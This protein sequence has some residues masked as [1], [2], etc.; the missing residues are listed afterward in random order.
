MDPAGSCFIMLGTVIQLNCGTHKFPV[1]KTNK[2]SQQENKLKSSGQVSDTK[3]TFRIFTAFPTLDNTSRQCVKT[4]IKVTNTSIID[5]GHRICYDSHQGLCLHADM[6]QC[7]Q[8]T[9]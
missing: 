6:L 3:L 2:E 7:D 4:R 1:Q 9:D 8:S 5:T